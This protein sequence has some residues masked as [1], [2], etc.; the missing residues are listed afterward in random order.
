MNGP[1]RGRR[2]GLCLVADPKLGGG[3][4]SR[5]LQLTSQSAVSCRQR[6]PLTGVGQT[7]PAVQN[8]GL[9]ADV[10]RISRQSCILVSRTIQIKALNGNFP[11]QSDSENFGAARTTISGKS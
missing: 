2:S 10:D 3:K 4:K 7:N 8:A 11:T 1:H 9:T 5:Q 6:S